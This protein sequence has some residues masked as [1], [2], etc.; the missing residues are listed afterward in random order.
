M[1]HGVAWVTVLTINYIAIFC[2]SVSKKPTSVGRLRLL[3]HQIRNS[4]GSL[5]K[6]ITKIVFHNK[7]TSVFRLDN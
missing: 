1:K 7:S 4:R 5:C 6:N 2:E 3:S